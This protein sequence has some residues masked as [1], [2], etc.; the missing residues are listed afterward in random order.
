[1]IFRA[2]RS[3]AARLLAVSAT[4]AAPICA[5]RAA[6][7]PLAWPEIG[8]QQRPWAIWWWLGSAV[9]PAD[10]TTLLESYRAAGLG[11][12]NIVPIY[13]VKGYE[14]DYTEFLGPAWMERLAHTVREG[15]RLNL[16]I[17][18]SQSS[19]WNFG[20]PWIAPAHAPLKLVW[21][22]HPV[23]A[24]QPPPATI[25][26][27]DEVDG[28]PCPLVA[29][30]AY[31]ATGTGPALDLAGK[32]AADGRLRWQ[33][34]AGEGEWQLVALFQS[35]I[36]GAVVERAG[37]GG[38][39]HMANPFSR[40]AIQ[41]H[42]RP[43]EAAFRAAPEARPRAFYHDSY[44]YHHTTWAPDFLAQFQRRRG[45]DLRTQLPALLG[46]GP[47]ATVGRVRG[48]YRETISDL[49]LEDYIEPW[50]QWARQAGRQT[51]NQAHGAPA[52]LLDVYAAADIPETETFHSSRFPIPGLRN[53]AYT[54]DRPHPAM[55]RFASSAA[56]IAGRA[57]V[58]AEACTWLEEHFKETL[59]LAK[60]EADQLFLNGINHLFYHGI[61]ASPPA[62][63]W[64]GWLFY[65]ST[66][67][68]PSGG[69]WR[70]LPAFNDYIARCQSILQGGR[71]DNDVL[72]YYPAHDLWQR[73]AGLSPRFGD[74]IL[75]TQVHHIDKWLLG[76]PFHRAY[77][78]LAASGRSADYISDRYVERTGENAGR[79]AVGSQ[80]YAAL[81][82]PTCEFM[83][84]A[85]LRRMLD[86]AAAGATVVFDGELPRDVP[87]L[88]DLAARTREL[89]EL[90][91][92]LA[93]KETGSPSES[94]AVVG[95][96]RVFKTQQVAALLDR[97]R[98]PREPVVDQGVRFI[99]RRHDAGHHYFLASLGDHRLDGWTPLGVDA[100]SAVVMD[101]LTG[102]TGVAPLMRDATG[103]TRVYLQLEPGQSL[104]LRTL[105]SAAA[106]GPRWK[107]FRAAGA[108]TALAGEW[109]VAFIAGGPVLPRPHAT[110]QLVSWTQFPDE[111]TQRFAGTARYR[112]RFELP[113]T[114]AEEWELDL[115]V[116]FE[117][118]RVRINGHDA[119]GAF[120]LPMRLRVGTWLKPGAND[121][122]IEV[123][124]TGANRIRDLDRR[125]VNWKKFHDINYVS[126]R[127][128]RFNAA[129]WPLA[130]AG[131][132]GPVRLLPLRALGDNPAP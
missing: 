52:N 63:E 46:H 87:G 41:S 92:R 115:G 117:T 11:G 85:T 103:A 17:D 120:S 9:K 121:L 110:A 113:A 19:G 25:A 50:T 71:P 21:Q 18:L 79:L 67:F 118:A 53:D 124:N 33:P 88:G 102:R 57:L 80:D 94:V 107:N 20:G 101:P 111:E 97:L 76:T 78:A 132:I 14:R 129:S 122:E 109:Q 4:L 119:G 40:A 105:E 13:G 69:V 125:G 1:M 36:K 98:V 114:P 58:S 126:I 66:N 24:T 74:L 73:P 8:A 38:A 7:S 86:L 96:G 59:A 26:Q 90:A 43:F 6:T 15:R 70:E 10:L 35:K 128:G 91:A 42:V 116:V 82:V 89:H 12:L 83:P 99:R 2:T 131:L 56:H 27:R 68:G 37:P 60:P 47:G 32:L 49:H 104:I 106:E 31:P 54:F 29:L 28:Q 23:S 34:P 51:R 95:R 55:I 72:L 30:M 77:E 45:Y 65:A 100:Q 16:G 22:I 44:E 75:P 48:D 64:P 93:W 62:A 130:E 39:G 112:L 123:T 127:Y 3:L 84:P 81:V 61:P 5:V 108:P